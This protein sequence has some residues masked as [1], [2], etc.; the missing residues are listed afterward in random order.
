MA[1]FMMGQANRDSELMVFDWELAA[2]II[3]EKGI[4][5][6]SA[7]LQGDWDYTGGSI[8]IDGK[9]ETDEW[10]NLYLASTWAIPELEI[11]G[12][13]MDCFKMQSETPGWGSETFWPEEALKILKG[14]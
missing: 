7:G 6:A 5:N 10:S 14:E 2:K 13:R 3:K 9:P 4:K 1:A 12:M 11:D 8:L